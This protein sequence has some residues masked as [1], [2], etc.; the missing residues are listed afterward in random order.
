MIVNK[1]WM[2]Q[3]KKSYAN[4]GKQIKMQVLRANQPLYT[5][6]IS[7]RIIL[8]FVVALLIFP[9]TQAYAASNGRIF[10]QLLNGTKNNAPVAAQSVTLQMAQ[11][12]TAKDLTTVKTDAHGAFAF[13][14]LATDKT[15]SY[16]IYTRYQGAQYYTNLIDLSNKLVQQINLTVYEATTSTAQIA[17]VQATVLLHEPDAQTG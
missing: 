1:N 11:G 10:G 5:L 7:V 4:Y 9:T 12:N 13:N 8:A 15:L 14:N 6:R 2:R 16:A 3:L 17:I